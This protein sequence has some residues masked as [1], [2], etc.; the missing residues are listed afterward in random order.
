MG[1]GRRNGPE[2]LLHENHRK[3]LPNGNLKQGLTL[4][5]SRSSRL[6]RERRYSSCRTQLP[7]HWV[8]TIKSSTPTT[9]EI[10]WPPV[11]ILSMS[12]SNVSNPIDDR[13]GFYGWTNTLKGVYYGPGS[14][15][16][17]LPN[18]LDTLEVKKVLVITGHSLYEK[19]RPRYLFNLTR[20]IHVL[21]RQMWFEWSR[22]S[23]GRPMFTGP[24]SMRLESTPPSQESAKGW[25]SSRSTHAT[26]SWPSEG[27]HR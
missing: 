17:A 6:S 15:A 3:C 5:T 16:T 20:K 22:K 13:S 27:G 18:L 1:D 9:K 10:Y 14:L 4:G 19:V 25:T 8:L 21:D 11:T 2:F 24:P 7:Q 12:P 23:S 26:Q